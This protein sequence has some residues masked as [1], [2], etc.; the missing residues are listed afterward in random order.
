M[1]ERLLSLIDDELFNKI[2]NTRILLVGLGGVGGYV[3]ESL[4]RSGFKDFLFVDGDVIEESNLNRQIIATNDNIGSFKTDEAK[5]MA[6]SIRKDIKIDTLN[7]FFNKDSFDNYI[8]DKY[9]YIIDACDDIYVKVE[10]IRYAKENN[11]K[12]ISALGTGRKLDASNV[13]I[14][15]L[16]K[17]FNDPLAKKLRYT[18]KKENISLDIPVVF[19]S[20]DA[21]KTDGMIGSA[22]FVPAVAG[23]LMANYVFLDIINS[24]K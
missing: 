8:N 6:I 20:E 19:S 21:I 9:D 12:I 5:S 18:L 24:G 22:V 1:D 3:L 23:I 7:V 15:S 10:L 2:Q 13:S 16:N 14:T 11:I 4:V 17:T